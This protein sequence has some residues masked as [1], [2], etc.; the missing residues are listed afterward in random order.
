ML[1]QILEARAGIRPWAR[2]SFPPSGC[3]RAGRRRRGLSDRRAR[4]ARRRRRRAARRERRACR[5]SPLRSRARNTCARTTP[6][7]VLR[8]AIP[9]PASPSSAARATISSGCEAPRRN[10]KFVIAASSAK[11]GSKAD[12]SPSPLRAGRRCPPKAPDEG[13]TPP[14]VV[15]RLNRSNGASR[16][17]TAATIVFS[18][19]SSI[20]RQHVAIPEPQYVIALRTSHCVSFVVVA[21]CRHVASH[22]IRRRARCSKQTKSTM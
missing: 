17:S 7:S 19:F 12:H 13:L 1:Q 20:A 21:A 16:P 4:P 10:E 14:S 11:R 6:A 5:P 9:I 8:S 3:G 22:R 18:T 15:S 2:A